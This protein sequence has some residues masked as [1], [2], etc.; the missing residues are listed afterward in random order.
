MTTV[1]NGS[2]RAERGAG[3]RETLCEGAACSAVLGACR[4]VLGQCAGFLRGIG[5]E[6]FTR[7]S[8]AMGGGTIGQHVRHALDHFSAALRTPSGQAIDYDHRR[9]A[10]AVE[11]ELDA[12]IGEIEALLD[13][14]GEDAL[15]GD[16]TVRVMVSSAGTT[17]DLPSTLQRELAFAAH[18][19]IHHHAMIGAIAREFG[20]PVGAGFGKAPSTV[21]AE[22]G[23]GIRDQGSG[24]RE[25]RSEESRLDRV[26]RPSPRPSP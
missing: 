21:E 14:L 17:A 22:R 10:T 8:A 26:C 9:R 12:A 23:G 1:T 24:K 4:G 7:P 11:R 2:I 5:A 20:L 15:S 19:A 25:E 18:H 16:V 6:D 13:A 3:A